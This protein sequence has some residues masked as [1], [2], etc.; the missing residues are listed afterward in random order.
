MEWNRVFLIICQWHLQQFFWENEK[1]VEEI[2][3]H[4]TPG[5]PQH[6]QSRTPHIFRP[7]TG[8]F[9]KAS[10]GALLVRILSHLWMDVV[11]CTAR[12][13]RIIGSHITADAYSLSNF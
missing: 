11:G 1:L 6:P 8:A 3:P 5:K 10:K 7:A 4:W 13:K 12:I 2:A 9:T